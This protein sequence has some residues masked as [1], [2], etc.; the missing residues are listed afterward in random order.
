MYLLVSLLQLNALVVGNGSYILRPCG[1]DLHGP[2]I[3][4]MF[5]EVN[6]TLEPDDQRSWPVISVIFRFETEFKELCQN[7]TILHLKS[8]FSYLKTCIDVSKY[9]HQ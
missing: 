9:G 4:M 5:E 2:T 6:N 1:H 3:C 7:V 8:G